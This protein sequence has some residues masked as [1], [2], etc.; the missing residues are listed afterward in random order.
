MLNL[1]L[2]RKTPDLIEIYNNTKFVGEFVM[3]LDGFYVYFPS[4]LE[5]GYIGGGLNEIFLEEIL[6]QLKKINDSWRKNINDFFKTEKPIEI[7]E[8]FNFLD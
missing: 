8:N 3:D 6:K 2:L 4:K 7:Q 5:S 1:K